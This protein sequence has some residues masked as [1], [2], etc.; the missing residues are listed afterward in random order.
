MRP[1]NEPISICSCF[2]KVTIN[3]LHNDVDVRFKLWHKLLVRYALHC[4]LW[5]PIEWPV[6]KRMST[7][8]PAV[9]KSIE[10]RQ[11]GRL[12]WREVC[13]KRGESVEMFALECYSRSAGRHAFHW[14]H[15][16]YHRKSICFCRYGCLKRLQL[17]VSKIS[18]KNRWD[19]EREHAPGA[20]RIR[21]NNAK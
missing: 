12:G 17:T 19:S 5:W 18:N 15:S 8:W 11:S 16:I 3:N 13:P 9:S 14:P 21:W 7:V 6:R 1:K 4:C 2:E 20:T 10:C